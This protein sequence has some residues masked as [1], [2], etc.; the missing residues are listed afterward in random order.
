MR[1]VALSSEQ[2]NQLINV[3]LGKEKADLA[4]INGT[5][6]NVYTG[7]LLEGFSVAS[8]GERIAYLGK[9][10]APTIGPETEVIDAKGKTLIPGLIDAHTHLIWYY[11]PDEFLRYAMKGGTT[12]V[13]TE[14]L[15][16]AF[17]LGYRG[18]V[19][20]LAAFDH[21]PVKIFAAA[22]VMVSLSPAAQA[23]AI[24]G[25]TLRKLLKREDVVGLGET[26][27]LPV[28]QGD[29]RILDL[30]AETQA[31]RKKLV[32]HTAG[33]RG[34]KLAAYLACGF[35][36]CHEPINLEEVM[37]RLRLG[38][39]VLVREGDMRKDLEAI[40]RIKDEGIDL[41]RLALASDGVTPK[42][43][44]EKGY[45]EVIV[46]KAID[47]GFDPVVAI[48][49]ATLNAA[50]HLSL[51][52]VIGGIAPGKYADIVILP[53]IR[54]IEAE[55]VIS[56]GRV[57]AHKGQLILQPRRHPFPRWV[58]RSIRLP[59]RLEPA[60]FNIWVEG[61]DG[62][63]R[64]RVIDQVTDLVTREAQVVMPVSRGM[65]EADIDKDILKAAVIDFQNQPGKMFVGLVRGFGMKRGAFASSNAWD[66]TGIVVV[67]VNGEDMA[68][69]AN[70][71]SELQGGMVVCADGEILSELP[72]P[73]G[74]VV[75]DLPM[76]TIARGLADV[77]QKAAGLGIPFP[78][79]HLT[80]TILPTPAIPFLRIC[81]AGLVDVREGGII[82]LRIDSA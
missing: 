24:D 40:S 71:V 51:D 74:G 61:G 16:V 14:T 28:I 23:K 25:G 55:Y 38:I 15:E 80:L 60:D 70:R 52:G 59:R 49:M 4:I 7:E 26:Y 27:W 21:Q 53:D 17:P 11:R 66:V 44:M 20:F 77:Q 2:M 10:V 12:S 82:S 54:K 43:L 72:L 75:S 37:E 41:R 5:L 76:E 64:V 13:I 48:Q 78:D 47:L 8:K 36:A 67:G 6:L 31:S 81:E 39:H 1:K 22:P 58:Y 35:C 30:F 62:Q 73:I 56:N 29:G 57:I 63:A 3:A 19:E 69:A 46:Q 34:N 79:A 65:I 42:Q 45:M 18:V 33:A 68:Q 32:G 50:E 9:D